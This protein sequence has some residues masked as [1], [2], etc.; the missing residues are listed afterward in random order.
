MGEVV[1]HAV[2]GVDTGEDDALLECGIETAMLGRRE[3]DEVSGSVVGDD[4]VEVVTF[5]DWLRLTEYRPLR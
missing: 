1:G 4:A 5:E 3:P 2:G